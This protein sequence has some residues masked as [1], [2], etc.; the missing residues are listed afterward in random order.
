MKTDKRKY[1]Y[2]FEGVSSYL[3]VFDLLCIDYYINEDHNFY[4]YPEVMY[5]LESFV[6]SR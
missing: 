2:Y 3:F 6:N 4:L 1:M 5:E